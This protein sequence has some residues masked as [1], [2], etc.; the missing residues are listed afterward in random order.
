LT[1]TVPSTSG[2]DTPTASIIGV[3]PEQVAHGTFLGHLLNSVELSD[4]I[5]G[6]DTGRKTSVKAENLIFNNCSQ[7]QV[8]EEFGEDF[9]YVGIAVLPEALVVKTISNTPISKFEQTYTWVIYLLS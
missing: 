1:E 2:R 4:L 6:V 7:W 8:V 9:P 5:E 3:R